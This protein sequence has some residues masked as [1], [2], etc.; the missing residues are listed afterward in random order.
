MSVVSAFFSTGVMRPPS[1]ML[2]ATAT[3]ML[4]AYVMP[5][6]SPVHAADPCH[7]IPSGLRDS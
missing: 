1:G 3:L 7:Q 4:S 2:T 6:A 5:L